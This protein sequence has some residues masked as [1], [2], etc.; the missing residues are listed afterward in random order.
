M[1]THD[2]NPESFHHQQRHRW[3]GTAEAWHRWWRILER[4]G[5]H[6]SERLLDLAQLRPGQQVLDV[7]TGIGE[8]AL[9]AARRVAPG[10]QV[11]AVDSSQR[12]LELARLRAAEQAVDNVIFRVADAET[13][14]DRL[15]G[16]PFDAVLSRWGLMLLPD[17]SRALGRLHAVLRPGGYLALAV[18][19]H[20]ERVP[21]IA[22]PTQVARRELGLP[23]PDPAQPTAFS[24]ADVA[25]LRQL[26]TAAG[27]TGL[28][29]EHL[30][31]TT[32]FASAQE[33]AH[34]QAD[35]SSTL[36]EQLPRLTPEAR[37]RFLAVL[38]VA[39]AP[40]ADESGRLRLE[41]R[42]LLAVGRKLAG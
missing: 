19:D 30:T 34:F 2:F 15:P 4:G 42:T 16:D 7:A 29:T 39:A 36:R 3:D 31:V 20:P 22:L 1:S 13:L 27:F 24:L 33:F 25:Q 12:M 41:N 11:L 18:W 8:P 23:P 6:C 38:A 17:P 9:S 5:S 21:M 26:L 14:P 37:V 35:I 28:H 40:Y 10:G 32:E